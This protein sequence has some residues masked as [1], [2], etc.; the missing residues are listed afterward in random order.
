MKNEK[1]VYVVHCV[2][3]EGPLNEPLKET[4]IRINQIFGLQIEPSLAN[5]KKIQNGEIDFGNATKA[6]KKLVDPKLISFNKT[7]DDIQ[8]MLDVICSSH[9]RNR[10]CDSS[11]T[12]WTYNWFCLDHVGYDHNPRKRDLGHHKVFDFYNT[13]CANIYNRIDGI[14]FHYHPLPFNNMAHSCATS[15]FNE[16]H[17]FDIL[18]R[19]IIDRTWFPAV[20]RPGFHTIRPDSNWFLEQWI[21]FDY[22]NQS[23]NGE[24]DQ[25]DLND[26]RF[27][28]WRRAP[29]IWGAYHP[30]HDDYQIQG[31]CRR[32]IF[33][34]LNMRAR[35]R[36]LDKREVESAFD[37]AAQTG[38]AVLS[39]TNHDF[40]DMAS[41]ID[42]IYAMIE[43]TAHD[44]P[45]VKFMH[46]NA[47]DAAR[48]YLDI[49]TIEP[50]GLE[51][52]IEPKNDSHHQLHVKTKAKLF[53]PQPFLA[54]KTRTG[55]YYHDNFDFG[56]RQNIWN[57]TFDWQTFPL[58]DLE[59]IGVAATGSAGQVEVAVTDIA[60]G[61][62]T[63]V[64][65]N[66]NN[67][68]VE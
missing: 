33:R 27:G 68:A 23:S 59:K 1:T 43:E 16:N 67:Q 17:L 37:Q 8:R 53:G 9:F 15:Y 65:L 31:M 19:K 4:F 40:R 26:G 44:W 58:F 48:L 63:K 12:G 24:S 39:F 29:K 7:W 20:F 64:D 49:E 14:F 52:E 6:V 38:K 5:L 56:V 61:S 36:E 66:C 42:S 51:I 34:C 41:E 62:A 57:Y 50:L 22:S 11:D 18:A 13:N 28:D 46:C 30:S 21:P 47:L 35:L 60:T 55:S 32:W 2:D 10:Y 45:D 25:P 3:A 54:L